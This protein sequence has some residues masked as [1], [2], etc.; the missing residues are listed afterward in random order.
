MAEE[1]NVI[2]PLTGANYPTLKVQCKMSLL[3]DGLWK[4][5]NKSVI[6]PP[7]GAEGYTKF[8]N[9]RDCVLAMIVLSIDL[10]ST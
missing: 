4:I 3:K 8:I 2:V 7:Q 1:K 9:R 6:A 5:V 10:F